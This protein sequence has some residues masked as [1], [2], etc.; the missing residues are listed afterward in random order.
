VAGWDLS[1][2]TYGGVSLTT[3][4]LWTSGFYFKPDGSMLF[5]GSML[6]S[7][8][9]IGIRTY[10]LSTPW[11]LSSASFSGTA[12][13]GT[14]PGSPNYV[15]ALAFSASGTKMFLVGNDDR[16]I[17]QFTLSSAW[18]VGTAAYDSISFNA[19]IGADGAFGDGAIVFSSDG[20]TVFTYAGTTLRSFALASPWNFAVG[21]T[22]ISVITI[23]VPA[24]S[25]SASGMF[26][27]PD[28]SAL[29]VLNKNKM[30]YE[31]ELGGLWSISGTVPYSGKSFDTSGQ[32]GANPFQANDMHFSVDGLRLFTATD[33]D[34]FGTSGKLY[35]YNVGSAAFWHNFVRSYEV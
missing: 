23:G 19:N 16:Y 34:N 30:V 5:V 3:G 1:A 14:L 31:Y 4:A 7:P 6:T 32:T 33:N 20:L 21:P 27:K 22:P 15:L 35:Q 24:S 2:A 10:T 25:A 11:D 18:N 17:K 9:R 28:G 26:F 12:D 29:F 13:L 8:Y